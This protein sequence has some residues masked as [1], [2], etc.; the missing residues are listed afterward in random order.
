MVWLLEVLAYIYNADLPVNHHI[1]TRGQNMVKQGL[2]KVAAVLE[3]PVED[4]Y[5]AQSAMGLEKL[6]VLS[7]EQRCLKR[8]AQD[9]TH[10]EY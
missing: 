1:K 2:I 7:E 5:N 3:I 4:L 6:L 10:P 8:W 9:V